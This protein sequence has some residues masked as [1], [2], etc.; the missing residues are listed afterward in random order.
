MSSS[1][2]HTLSSPWLTEKCLN[3]AEMSLEA[4][5]QI[6]KVKAKHFWKEPLTSLTSLV[7]LPKK[8][9]RDSRD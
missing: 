5:Q 4:L 3:L 6:M 1:S 7:L 9:L 2:N 8:T